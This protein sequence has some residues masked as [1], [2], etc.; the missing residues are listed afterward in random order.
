MPSVGWSAAVAC[1]FVNV[2]SV[3]AGIEDLWITEVMPAT[4]E[5]EVTNVGSEAFTVPGA[6]M[7]FC[8]SRRY[9][10]VLPGNTEF[11]PGESKSFT[12]STV[13]AENSDF[14]LYKAGS[15][16]NPDNL[17]NGLRWGATTPSRNRMSE[18]VS[19]GA[20][21]ATDAFVD[22]PP[23]GQSLQLTG[24]DPFSPDN[25]S[26][27]APNF[28]AFETPD[29]KPEFRFTSIARDG[30]RSDLEWQG[31][32]GP[33]Q[34]QQ[35][36]ALGGG[37][38]TNIGDTV[39]AR[40][41]SVSSGGLAGFFR[42]LD[43]DAVTQTAQY[44]VT[45]SGLW[46]AE[47]HPTDFPGSAHFSPLVGV[48]HNADV[49]FWE[50]GGTA[51][52][53]VERIAETGASGEFFDDVAAAIDNGTAGASMSANGSFDSPGSVEI[54]FNVDQAHPYV[55]LLSMLAPSPDWFVGVNGLSL[56][57]NGTWVNSLSVD[58][59]PYDAGTEDGNT[60]SLSNPATEPQG[61]IAK[62][63]GAPF[64]VDGVVAPVGRFRFERID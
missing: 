8:H 33:F 41:V 55:S 12:L 54:V 9:N 61:T 53:G 63:A 15:F 47:T 49:T 30:D 25:W 13:D 43:T 44:C 36:T 4:G 60:F 35:R 18:A 3:H 32:D 58:L 42:V 46:S 23:A 17:L 11:Q 39:E 56:L 51:T 48:T 10:G 50:A 37:D 45:F 57:Q 59:Q 62:I 14:W 24:P 28:G 27:G 31:G 64:D 20:W 5:V 26:A 19:A 52:L 29:P 6:G 16:S 40:S 38:W 34:V 21:P 22:V 2:P 7:P 1:L